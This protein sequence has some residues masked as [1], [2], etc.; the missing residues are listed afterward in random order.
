MTLRGFRV[1]GLIVC[2]LF[3]FV[4]V[5]SADTDRLM[6]DIRQKALVELQQVY[7]QDLEVR[8]IRVLK[9]LDVIADRGP[10][11]LQSIILG[12]E[13]GK[14][15]VQFAVV[16]IDRQQLRHTLQ[17]EASYDALVDVFVSA[18][19]LQKG[20]RLSKSDFYMTKGKASRFSTNTIT[21]LEDIEGKILR[22]NIG[23]NVVLRHD[24]ITE[25]V[26][27]KR[28]SKVEIEVQ[29]QFVTVSSKGIL[30]ADA[31]VGSLATVFCET[32]K[33]ELTGIMT[34]AGKVIVRI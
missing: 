22:V 25:H 14:N 26:T 33:K 10:L 12:S 34:E 16:V 9:G 18:K 30:R 15:T 20:T 29:G 11:R 3:V 21:K 13:T 28:G 8:H 19:S 1:I 6:Q 24:H 4:T 2:L 31:T 23:P 5:V 7:G 17:L 27:V 32:Y